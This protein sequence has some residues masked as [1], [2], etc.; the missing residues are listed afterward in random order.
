M[1]VP[2]TM[3]HDIHTYLQ[4]LIFVPLFVMLIVKLIAAFSIVFVP[5]CCVCVFVFA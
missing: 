4:H 2:L 1:Y 3:L 5:F